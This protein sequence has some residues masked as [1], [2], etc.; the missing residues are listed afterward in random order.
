MSIASQHQGRALPKLFR[1]L[2][3][4]PA[5]GAPPP[6]TEPTPIRAETGQLAAFRWPARAFFGGQIVLAIIIFALEAPKLSGDFSLFA[7]LVVLEMVANQ[8]AFLAYGDIILSSDFA[9]VMAILVFFG[10][11]GV[12]VA[13]PFGRVAA[14]LGPSRGGVFA[15]LTLSNSARFVLVG[16]V[17]AQVYDLFA[18][19]NPVEVEF[20]LIPAAIAVTVVTFVLYLA[21]TMAS[22]HLRKGQSL[23]SIWSNYIWLA[24][25]Y[26]ALGIVG[27]ALAAAY[28]GLGYVGILAFCMPAL[29]MRFAQKQ[30]VDKTAESVEQL[31]EKN[32]A[33]EVANVEIKTVHEELRESYDATLE[34][35]VGALDARD[36]E[37]KGH[38]IRVAQYMLTIAEALGVKPGSKEWTDMQ[39][40]ALLHDV[41]KIGVSDNILLKPGKLT[42][43]EWTDMRRHPEIGFNI[44]RDVS[45][46]RGA[47][48]IVLAHHERWDGGG[49]PKGL[50]EDEILLGARIFPVVDTFDSMTSDRPYR[51][52][53][54]ARNA[55]DEILRCG[56]SQFDPLVVEAFLD[57]YE[58]WV[59]ERERMHAPS[60]EVAA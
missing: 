15:F 3:N 34:A 2:L 48:E 42:P 27:I 45:F 1:F 10:A 26:A 40:G 24:P 17:S 44:L 30:Y 52:A 31:R 23:A 5:G 36:Q 14:R 58:K 20:E 43:E 4:G 19:V 37:T 8:L 39:R 57:I 59:I 11:P 6:A 41:G 7:L 50:R 29:M 35:L 51:K 21:F 55:L 18:Q 12:V 54:S 22:L 28:I 49:Y 13:A 9:L 46:L 38:S 32:T 47:A 33:L 56:G 60:L 53:L 16:F 25:H